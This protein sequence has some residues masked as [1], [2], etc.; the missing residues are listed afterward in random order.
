MKCNNHFKQ[1]VD[2]CFLDP[3]YFFILLFDIDEQMFAKYKTGILPTCNL[4]RDT[5]VKLLIVT[6]HDPNMAEIEIVKPCFAN[7][8]V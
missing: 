1:N 2:K 7:V 3:H 4:T 8:S 6:A 5:V